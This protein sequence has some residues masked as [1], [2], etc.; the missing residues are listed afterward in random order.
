MSINYI[1]RQ[2]DNRFTGVSWPHSNSKLSWQEEAH[3]L[4]GSLKN[5]AQWLSS[6]DIYAPCNP[7]PKFLTR[8]NDLL[9]INE[10]SNSDGHRKTV[11]SVFC[12]LL[13]LA[14]SEGR[15]LPCCKLPY[16][17]VHVKRNWCLWPIVS[18]TWTLPT[19][20]YVSFEADT[21]QSMLELR[22]QLQSTIWWQILVE[23]LSWRHWAKLFLD[24]WLRVTGR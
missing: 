23:S 1:N 17:E 10:I 18:S 15:Q 5:R 12:C 8:F 21:P 20:T 19:V 9:P 2:G 3:G 13:L 7:L 11:S 22:P 24:S 16:G 14:C 6:L 4:S